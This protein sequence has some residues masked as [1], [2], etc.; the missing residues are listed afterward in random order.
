M[1]KVTVEEL[2]VNTETLLSSFY[3]LVNQ[4]NVRRILVKNQVGETL[5]DL[6]LSVGL[7][8]AMIGAALVPIVGALGAIGG[9][10]A[11]RHRRGWPSVPPKDLIEAGLAGGQAAA[12][13]LAA[14]AGLGIAGALATNLTLVV[15]R[16]IEE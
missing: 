5:V 16:E 6:P 14:I 1:N 12:T 8:G 9:V 7:T 3:D 15:E 13:V 11:D 10:S 2:K 4:S